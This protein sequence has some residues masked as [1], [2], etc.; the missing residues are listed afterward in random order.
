MSKMLQWQFDN[1]AFF[2]IKKNVVTRGSIIGTIRP[3]Y[4]LWATPLW[5]HGWLPDIQD[6]KIHNGP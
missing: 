4:I 6:C 1:L 5:N 3:K 2:D